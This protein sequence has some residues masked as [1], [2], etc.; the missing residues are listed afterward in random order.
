MSLKS[1]LRRQLVA[2][3]RTSEGFLADFKTPQQWLKQVHD[4][5]N[6]ALWFAGHMAHSDNFFISIIAPEKAKNNLQF[7][8][9]FGVGS[10]PTSDPAD[11]PSP[12]EVLE[13]MRK[14]YVLQTA[15]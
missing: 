9:R 8:T 7:S 3:R 10:H 5:A 14:I 2:A 6:H 1:R 4:S 15:K 11:Y 12:A 13:T